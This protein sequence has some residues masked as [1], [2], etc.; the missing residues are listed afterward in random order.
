M[1]PWRRHDLR[2][3][4]FPTSQDHL[5]A[6]TL[7]A[8][9]Q[10]R[11]DLLAVTG[12]SNVTGEVWPLEGTR[13]ARPRARR[14]ALRRRRPARAPPRDRHGR[15]RHRPPR[16][17]RPQALR[18]VRSGRARQPHAGHRR[19]ADPGRRRD[20]ARHRRRRDLGRR[21]G[22]LRGG[23]TERDRRRR[24]RR[25]LRRARHGASPR[26]ASGRSPPACTPGWRRS[27]ASPPTSCGRSTA[28]ASA[29]RASTSPATAITSSP[30][31]LSD[32]FAI[33]VRHGC[34]CAHPLLTRLLGV[35][36]AEARRL[37]TSCEPAATPSCPGRSGPASGSGARLRTSTCCSPR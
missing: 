7:Q 28:T 23:I 31:R 37:H 19:P 4:P 34:F 35:S 36:D 3:L 14:Q 22:A 18:A 32:D 6:T 5:L 29:S 33:G 27:P 17:L 9:Q 30:Q 20:Q 13:R 24:A 15:G 21:A 26:R 10:R 16:A 1:L 12:A 8:L 2:V 11:T 25:G